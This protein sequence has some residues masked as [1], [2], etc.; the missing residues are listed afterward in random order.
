MAQIAKETK[1][2]ITLNVTATM[3]FDRETIER[4][5]RLVE[6]Y[7]NDNPHLDLFGETTEDGHKLEFRPR[8]SYKF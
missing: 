8:K 7:W 6:W 1:S 3:Q 2:D 5:L 4:C